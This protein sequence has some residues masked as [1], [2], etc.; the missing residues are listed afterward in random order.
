MPPLAAVYLFLLG[1][2]SGIA[3]L[4]VTAYRRVSP[5]WLKWLLVGSGLLASTRYAAMAVFATTPS[6]ERWGLLRHGWFATSLSLT[7]ASV[8]AI[9]QLIR[10]PAM[11]PRKLLLWFSPFFLIYMAVIL[12]APTR[13]VPDPVSGWAVRLA[14]GWQ[15]LLAVT[16]TIFVIAFLG[17][18]ATLIGK[19][20]SKPIR[21]AL[22]GLAMGQLLLALDGLLVSVGVW[23]FR[24][25][26]YSEMLMLLALWHAYETGAAS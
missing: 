24:P 16:H 1:L 26:L 2:A 18:C 23:Y 8:C 10:H 3:V 12:V 21:A 11:S 25:Y 14:P 6:P 19:I 13:L 5:P 7:L 22:L 9:D 20:P 17:G 15:G 4:T